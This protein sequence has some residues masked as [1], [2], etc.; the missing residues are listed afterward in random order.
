MGMMTLPWSLGGSHSEIT[1][2][3]L[4]SHYQ[5][6]F[7]RAVLID[8]IIPYYSRFMIAQVSW[9]M[10]TFVMVGFQKY[11]IIHIILI[12]FDFRL[13]HDSLSGTVLC[14]VVDLRLPKAQWW[15]GMYELIRKL[16]I[17]EVEINYSFWEVGT[18]L[19]FDEVLIWIQNCHWFMSDMDIKNMKY[20][21]H[22]YYTFSCLSSLFWEGSLLM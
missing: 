14:S 22:Y 7:F 5:L 18:V 15:Q 19:I 8:L 4:K 11:H 2:I 6:N 3:S 16:I 20:L 1:S 17:N 21:I 10:D 9:R 12:S 13:Q